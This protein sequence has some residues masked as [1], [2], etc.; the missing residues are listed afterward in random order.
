MKRILFAMLT[1]VILAGCLMPEE[2][3]AFHGASVVEFKNHR[4]TGTGFMANNTFNSRTVTQAVV[5]DSV[6]VQLV[7]PHR[8]TAIEASWEI[9]AASTAVEGVNYTITST[10]GTVR[11]E[12][13]ASF[14]WIKF[15]VLGGGIPAGGA[16]RTIVFRLNGSNEVPASENYRTFNYN[17]R[18]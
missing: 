1:G 8:G 9:D 12:P 7:G 6:L 10:K 16:Q 2:D 17:I 11:I 18:P 13:N 15:D 5:R 4:T 14:G 3:K